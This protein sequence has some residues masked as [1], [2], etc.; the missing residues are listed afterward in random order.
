MSSWMIVTSPANF[1]STAR[2]EFT[3]QGMKSRH[4]KKAMNMAPGDALIYYLTGVAAFAAAAE[5]AS[6]YFEDRSRIWSAPGKP[7]EEYPWRVR[8]RNVIV[9]S[10][11]G[12][13]AAVDLKERLAYVRKWPDPHW[14][15]AFQ[16]N[17]HLIPDDDARLVR[18][19]LE[20]APVALRS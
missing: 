14:K 17:V 18:A 3:V 15:L 7:D 12:R 8:L 1:L 11:R 10:E 2:L 5:I 19:S 20:A 13:V 4:R 6:A 16:G 9:P